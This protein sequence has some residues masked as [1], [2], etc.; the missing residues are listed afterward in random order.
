MNKSILIT[1]AAGFI[2]FHSALALKKLGH[3]VVGLD[4]FNS[5]YN[6]ELKRERAAL[7]A[8]EG[9]E[10]VSDD[11]VN[12]EKLAELVDTSSCTHLLHLAAQAGVRYARQHPEAYLHSNIDG[13]LSILE[14]LK[15]RPN[16][17]LVYASSSS[18]YGRNTKIP[19]SVSDPTD[20]PANLY[21]ATKKAN[22]LMAYSYHHL[23]GIQMCGLRFF[24]VYGPW[25]RPDMAYF[26]F[27]EAIQA[28][29]PIHLFNEG[30]MQRDF[31]YIDDIVSGIIAA[32]DNATP[33]SLFNLGNHQPTSLFR[34]VSILED[35]LGKKA[36]IVL[37][38]P[39]PEEVEITYAEITD[40]EAKLGFKPTTSIE[41]GLE[42]F[43]DWYRQY[44]KVR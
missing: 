35:L 42:R 20:Q 17:K 34:F 10:V 41:Q 38:G 44:S 12:R 37:E 13:F 19:F 7:L 16:I 21:A 14:T 23:Y 6:P 11:L 28:G 32:L 8:K 3:T 5:Y 24:T 43:I 36:Q 39:S 30:K 18:V 4:N 9:I 1:G 40:S 25:G 22:E 2:G 29:R 31:T 27:T 33:Y 26:S 15:A